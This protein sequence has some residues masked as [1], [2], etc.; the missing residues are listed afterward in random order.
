MSEEEAAVPTIPEIYVLAMRIGVR[1]G[2]PEKIK[3]GEFDDSLWEYELNDGFSLHWNPHRTKSMMGPHGKPLP[4]L[5]VLFLFEG[6]QFAIANMR[7]AKGAGGED[8]MNEEGLLA[9]LRTKLNE[10]E[11]EKQHGISPLNISNRLQAAKES[12]ETDDSAKKLL[13]N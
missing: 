3:T 2:V 11:I 4:P 7:D 12:G 5:H 10:L 13:I 1:T 8:G 6:K 9:V